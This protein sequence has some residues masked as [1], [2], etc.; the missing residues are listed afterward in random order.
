MIM[1]MKNISEEV[2]KI[3]STEG[4]HFAARDNYS[5]SKRMSA[6]ARLFGNTGF[7]FAAGAAA[8]FLLTGANIGGISSPMAVPFC[9]VSGVTGCAAGFIGTALSC[10]F[11]GSF[12]ENAAELA[13][14]L[15]MLAVKAISGKKF[16]V[17][18]SV[19]LASAAYF[20]FGMLSAVYLGTGG[21][22]VAAVIFRT[23][24]CGSA[25]YIFGRASVMPF[26]EGTRSDPAPAFICGI[27]FASALCG[28]KIFI[29]DIGRIAVF[30]AAAVFARRYGCC[31]G[32][33]AAAA[34]GAAMMLADSAY[35]RSAAF[36]SCAA[37]AAGLTSNRGRFQTALCF[38][39]TSLLTAIIVGMP[40]GVAEYMADCAAAGII[41]FMIPERAYSFLMDIPDRQDRGESRHISS[42]LAFASDI[43]EEISGDISAARRIYES[44]EQEHDIASAVRIK[45]CS[46]CR[47]GDRCGVSSAYSEKVGCGTALESAAKLMARKGALGEDDLPSRF[48]RCVR[49]AEIVKVMGREKS[50]EE[51]RRMGERMSRETCAAAVEQLKVQRL[52]YENFGDNGLRRSGR[53]SAAAEDVLRSF[54]INVR[55]AAVYFDGSGR[56][57]AEAFITQKSN[58]PFDEMTERLSSVT[59]TAFDRPLVEKA[60]EKNNILR[61]RWSRFPEL[62]ADISI[63]SAAGGREKSGDSAELFSDGFGKRYVIIAD[64]MGS[65]QRAAEESCMAVSLIK[66]F[67]RSGTGAKAALSYTNLLLAGVSN[68]EIFTTADLMELDVYTGR[69]VFYKQGAAES[70]V[71]RGDEV[72]VAENSSLP[73]G[74]VTETSSEPLS[75]YLKA[76]DCAAMISD[77]VRADAAYIRETLTNDSVSAEVCA[78]R[79]V[80]SEKKEARREDD[81]TAAVIKLYR[82]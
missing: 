11:L 70:Y 54:E 7:R 46:G 22:A 59:G 45:V 43:L 61:C 10:I 9:A 24:I 5:A 66:R 27:I 65:G 3:G 16:S 56:A 36:L 20:G 73:L 19:I 14:E 33:A 75:F 2:S 1:E 41:F 78:D 57:F 6:A 15:F 77:G 21:A 37:L 40:S 74:I 60:G 53:L 25:A 44:K 23:A 34:G 72:L 30:I 55:S 18:G 51:R 80:S 62:I 48:G 63:K 31:G 42:K 47:S 4:K 35:S 68:D 67:I 69:C 49:K 39:F 52:L 32:A 8:A 28:T 71:R 76:G 82:Y 58:I 17:K 50:A 13:A 79:I 12:R 29:F 64:G 26:G 81:K 38:I